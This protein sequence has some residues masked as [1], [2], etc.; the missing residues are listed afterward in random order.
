MPCSART[1]THAA[2]AETSHLEINAPATP[3]REAKA[4]HRRDLR[5]G[6]QPVR[7]LGPASLDWWSRY[8]QS[9]TPA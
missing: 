3:D 5:L 9:M 2:D 7:S 1:G 4:Q 6:G 8:Q